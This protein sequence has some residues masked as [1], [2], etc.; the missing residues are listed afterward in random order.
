[1]LTKKAKKPAPPS[2]TSTTKPKRNS[3]SRKKLASVD[4][5]S[6]K[7]KKRIIKPD[8]QPLVDLPEE[9]LD[10]SGNEYAHSSKSK[11]DVKSE[12]Y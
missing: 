3:N 6:P 5:V 1:M 2:T 4:A 8:L 7:F 12:A 9:Q 11:D 10:S